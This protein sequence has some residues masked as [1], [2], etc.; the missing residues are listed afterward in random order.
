MDIT[1]VVNQLRD[2]QAA[3]RPGWNGYIKK[4]GSDEDGTGAL[5]FVKEGG[6]EVIYNRMSD[7]YSPATSP[8]QIDGALLD[9]ILADDWI[10]GSAADFERARTRT[11]GGGIW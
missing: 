11:G 7:G 9:G 8:L 2:G 3:K 4:T 1:Y 6:T 10:V 5:T